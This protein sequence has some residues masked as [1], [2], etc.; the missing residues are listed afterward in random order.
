MTGEA[1]QPELCPVCEETPLP[2]SSVRGASPADAPVICSP[3]RA[4]HTGE[5]ELQLPRDAHIGA[6]RVRHLTIRQREFLPGKGALEVLRQWEEAMET[7][8]A[9][10]RLLRALLEAGPSDAEQVAH[11]L[12]TGGE[13]R[14]KLRAKGDHFFRLTDLAAPLARRLATEFPQIA[15]GP[16]LPHAELRRLLAEARR[17]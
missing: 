12:L 11:V 1:I 4:E 3:C 7:G 15:S 14:F 9:Q 2:P 13:L 16:M 17:R 5:V 10:V 8:A 6:L